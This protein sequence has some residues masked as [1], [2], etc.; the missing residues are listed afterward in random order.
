[1]RGVVSDFAVLIAILSMVILDFLVG[2]PTPK[3][4]VP[5][6]FAVSWNPG[7]AICMFCKLVSSVH[8]YIRSI[9]R[10]FLLVLLSNS[11]CKL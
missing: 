3:L 6:D 1:M 10:M 4:H 11:L 2:I 9:A 7:N 5:D 8:V